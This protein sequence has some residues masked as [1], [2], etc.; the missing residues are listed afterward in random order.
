MTHPEAPQPVPSV[1]E[2]SRGEEQLRKLHSLSGALPVGGFLVLHLLTNAKALSARAA[3]DGALADI[4]Q[5]SLLPVIELGI[6]VPLVF[7]AAYGVKLAVEGR[8]RV[9]VSGAAEANADRQRWMYMLQRV[10]GLI[11]LAFIAYHLYEL[12]YQKLVGA[13]SVSAFYPTLCADLSRTSVGVPWIA[14]LYL[15]GIT[16][17]TFHFAHGLWRFVISWRLVVSPR[18]QQ[19]MATVLSVLGVALFLIG[20]DT[21]LFFATGSKLFVPPLP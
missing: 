4:N 20:L 14:L 5:L 10:S 9:D 21:A 18:S 3:F 7:H 12:R 17:C 13:M 11:A 1:H 2:R 19:I 15:I 8:A 16:A 6:L